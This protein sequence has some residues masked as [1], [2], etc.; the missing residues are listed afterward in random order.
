MNIGCFIPGRCFAVNAALT[1]GLMFSASSL[2]AG[3]DQDF[4]LADNAWRDISGPCLIAH[5]LGVDAIAIYRSDS[6]ELL[7][8]A[9]SWLGRDGRYLLPPPPS[10]A[11]VQFQRTDGQAIAEGQVAIE[12][13]PG[14]LP[15]KA[16]DA[17]VRAQDLRLAAYFGEAPDV[18]MIGPAY[19]QALNALDPTTE[20]LP[21]L[22]PIVALARNEAAA[23]FRSAGRL[24]EADVYYGLAADAFER[25]DD[26]A[27]LAASLNARGLTAWRLGELD[28]AVALYERALNLR[29]AQGDLYAVASIA[30]N[31]GL[32]HS[33]RNEAAD[34]ISWYEIALSILQGNIDLRRPFTD[35]DWRWSDQPPEADL[36]GALNTLG[37]LAL[38]LRQ[39]GQVDL[40]EQYWRNYMALEAHVPSPV[41]FARARLVF[42]QLLGARARLDEALWHL[43]AALGQFSAADEKRWIAETL[44]ELAALYQRLG[45]LDGA[46]EHARSAVSLGLEDPGAAADAQHR[47]GQLL[48]SRG[49]HAAALAALEQAA[50]LARQADS[51]NRQWKIE[52]DLVR[53]SF[54]LGPGSALLER[55]RSVHRELLAL[56]RP[57][58]AAAALAQL[59]EMYFLLDNHEAA[60]ASLE[61]A[62]AGHMAVADPIAEFQSLAL[63]GRVLASA[64]KPAA[65]DVNA[66][67]I[68]LAEQLRH[69]ALPVLRQAELFAS[70]HQVYRRQV[71]TLVEI[72]QEQDARAVADL[73]RAQPLWHSTGPQ[74]EEARTDLLAARSDLLDR[75]HRAR[76]DSPADRG[77]APGAVASGSGVEVLKREL[78]AIES[79][80]AMARYGSGLRVRPST[81]AIELDADTVL[82][83]YLLLDDR[84]LLW[85]TSSDGTRLEQLARPEELGADI[86][87]LKD[88]L[89]HPRWATGRIDA[90]AAV[91]GEAL[92]GPVAAELAGKSR[93]LVQADDVLHSVPFALLHLPAQPPGRP[94][95]DTHT[96]QM[97]VPGSRREVPPGR[98]APALVLMADPGWTDDQGATVMLP[99]HSLL[100]GLLRDEGLI[101]LPGSRIEAEAIAA[102]AAAHMPVRLRTGP[103]AS[104]EFIV[105]GGL[106]DF[107]IIHLATH[108]LVD[109]RYPML[110]SLL[111]ASEHAAGPAFLRPSE[112]ADLRLHAEL[113]VLSGCETGHG[114]ILPG[115]GA[116]S[117]ARP[118]LA[119]G[120]E[121]VLA[122]LWKIDDGRTARFM[123]RFYQHLLDDGLS[124]AEALARTQ[125]WT[126]HQA[127][128]T[129]PYY[130]AGFI[131]LQGQ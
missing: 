69:A 43:T 123:D 26:A 37:N 81:G 54:L 16:M 6:G 125:R 75:M 116:L 95:I 109:L 91:L 20:A 96:V 33:R 38:V 97:L 107:R 4:V 25:L 78:D 65:I 41:D 27:G 12:D 131:L 104:R 89:R 63:L 42:A 93:V 98:S 67:A 62:I 10:A 115:S 32:I 126:R 36:R 86:A 103:E 79:E 40:A 112:I 52:G 108:G 94:M 80:L 8:R 3:R 77:L 19:A 57:A 120:A 59:G 23:Y 87:A 58:E 85:V 100:A 124:P 46:L 29:H 121:Q 50:E 128:T 14:G 1:A 7:L 30:N 45:D 17:L 90:R 68:A 127:N 15:T 105:G 60:R 101:A 55:Q 21:A 49:D 119:A 110:S 117:L 22:L 61:A 83:S 84:I 118:F 122:S 92:L 11:S 5:N 35:G 99:E 47:L 113:V 130:W 114:R 13:C 129:H 28:R 44:T 82:L 66:R 2:G 74:G 24:S 70:L 18:A 53:A 88:W 34:A 73:A 56:G 71:Q 102:R 51:I 76:L 106:S 72:G 48:L 39:Q 31:L 9:G 111:L 64:D